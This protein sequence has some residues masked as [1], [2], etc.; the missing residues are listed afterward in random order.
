M[1]NLGICTKCNHC[2]GV[3]RRDP[4]DDLSEHFIECNVSNTGIPSPEFWNSD[5]PDG[6]PYVLEH[7]ITVEGV[8]I[9]TEDEFD[10][11]QDEA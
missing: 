5:V 3:Y 6:C 9:E 2:S 7:V 4:Y 10:G 11:C 8:K 1:L